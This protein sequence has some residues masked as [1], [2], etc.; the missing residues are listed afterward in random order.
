VVVDAGSLYS[1]PEAG[2]G[3]KYYGVGINKLAALRVQKHE[4]SNGLG[5]IVG[6][7]SLALFVEGS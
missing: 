5:L 7:P 1:A 3:G 4:R 2:I 6:L